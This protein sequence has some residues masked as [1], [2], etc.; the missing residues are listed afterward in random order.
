MNSNTPTG[1]LGRLGGGEAA[2]A[3]SC[4][5]VG[6]ASIVLVAVGARLPDEAKDT[7]YWLQ[8]GI[9]A[10]A[11]LIL[12]GLFIRHP[13]HSGRPEG[14]TQPLGLSFSLALASLVTGFWPG[15]FAA[16]VTPLLVAGSWLM[17]RSGRA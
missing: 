6:L 17:E 13:R 8:R 12:L 10:V 9:V 16:L 15:V 4:V 11:I 2:I 1:F 7:L 5:I 3:K 14:L